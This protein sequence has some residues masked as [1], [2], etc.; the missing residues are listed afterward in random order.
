MTT[1][2]RD[3]TCTCS[4]SGMP[5]SSTVW[6]PGADPAAP[7]HDARQTTRAAT[8]G[9]AG[10]ARRARFTL[11]LRGGRHRRAGILL[12]LRRDPGQAEVVHEERLA[13]EAAAPDGDAADEIAFLEMLRRVGPADEAGQGKNHVVPAIG[14]I[15]A[16]V[17]GVAV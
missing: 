12:V 1:L 7:V 5:A 9:R 6:G 10:R 2:S 4:A 8:P 11:R 16:Q 3:G 17:E 13:A 15:A 14:G